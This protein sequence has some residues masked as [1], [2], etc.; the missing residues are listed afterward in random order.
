MHIERFVTIE[1]AAFDS[2]RDMAKWVEARNG[3]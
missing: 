1:D 3:P 2:V